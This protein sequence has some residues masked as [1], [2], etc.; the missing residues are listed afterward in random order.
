[1]SA[2]LIITLATNPAARVLF[3]L[4]MLVLITTNFLI[5]VFAFG[6]WAL[7]IW[8]LMLLYSTNLNKW[9]TANIV[10]SIVGLTILA[11]NGGAL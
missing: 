5:H 10:A 8:P 4:L 3:G 2:D 11:F 1:M 9:R 6:L 7:L